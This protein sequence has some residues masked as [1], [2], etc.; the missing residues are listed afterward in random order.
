MSVQIVVLVS[1]L[2]LLIGLG[3][4]MGRKVK[5]GADFAIAGR[6]LP[7]WVAALSERATD[8]SAWM[9][10]G[11]PGSAYALGISSAWAC[12]GC[13]IGSAAVWFI[14]VERLRK[15]ADEVDALTYIDWVSK[16][17]KDNE[18]GIRLF[19]SFTIAFFFIIYVGAQFIG[20]GKTL[21]TL[22]KIDPTAGILITACIIAPY[23]LYGGF[24]SVVYTD[25]LQSIIMFAAMVLGPIVGI[26]YIANNPGDV[27]ATSIADA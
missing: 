6:D 18:K 12:I 3:V 15:D 24:G 5:S 20:G 26:M 23:T 9:L 8:C 19:G 1:Y 2:V 14:A 10:L 25:C 13:L 7:G 17:H 21:F 4:Y 22:F 11:V 16:R 27:Y